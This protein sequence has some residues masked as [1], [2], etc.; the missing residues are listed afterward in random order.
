MTGP[1]LAMRLTAWGAGLL[2]RQ[3]TQS[4]ELQRRL[5]LARREPV[6]PEPT[7]SLRRLC[8]ISAEIGPDGFRTIHLNRRRDAGA[9]H[10]LYL[11]GG[12]YVL[13][14]LTAHWWIV[15]QIIRR[16]GARFTVPI[17][18]LAPEHDR[19]AAFAMVDRLYDNLVTRAG[20][21]NVVLCGDSAGGGFAVSL[22][23]RLVAGGQPLPAALL[24]F[25]PWVDVTMADPECVRVERDDPILSV[26]NLRMS[27]AMWAGETDVKDPAISPFYGPVEDLPPMTIFQGDRDVLM[28]TSRDFA[29]R[30]MQA[31]V[32][33]DY[34]QYKGAFHVFN[35]AVFLPESKHV[36]ARIDQMFDRL[37]SEVVP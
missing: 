15:E 32:R 34:H 23:Q 11:H 9:I 25:A 6:A 22:A 4:V 5:L 2:F 3:L 28:P 14:L 24:L 37:Q 31:G 7:A 1:S 33:V 26:A 35:S 12:A 10:V 21:A 17:Y 8:T 27:G 19:R 13:Q 29:R 30:A 18:A 20:A 36:Y 16:T